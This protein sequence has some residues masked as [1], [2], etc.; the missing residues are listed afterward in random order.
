M[1]EFKSFFINY[2]F[3]EGVVFRVFH[4]EP[5][6]NNKVI[7]KTNMIEKEQNVAELQLEIWLFQLKTSCSIRIREK[8]QREIST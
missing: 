7:Y 5:I 1:T 6:G 3:L 4:I 8:Y 2:S